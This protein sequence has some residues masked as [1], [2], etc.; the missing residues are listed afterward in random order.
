MEISFNSREHAFACQNIPNAVL[1]DGS[2]VTY[3]TKSYN[4]A[5]SFIDTS[6]SIAKYYESHELVSAL[7]KM[8]DI[9]E[10]ILQWKKRRCRIMGADWNSE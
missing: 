10:T 2:I 4:E 1:K 6:I 9:S 8:E 5:S 3:A 7:H